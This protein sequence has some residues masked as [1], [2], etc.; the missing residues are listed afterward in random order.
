MHAVAFRK[1]VPNCLKRVQALN[2]K[3]FREKSLSLIHFNVEKPRKC[4][5]TVDTCCDLLALMVLYQK[6]LPFMYNQEI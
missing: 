5:Y 1:D 3:T 6:V 4:R 2:F